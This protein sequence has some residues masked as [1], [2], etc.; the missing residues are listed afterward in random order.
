MRQNARFALQITKADAPLAHSKEIKVQAGGL[1]G[2]QQYLDH[3]N[4]ANT[5]EL[6]DDTLKFDSESSQPIKNIYQTVKV[7][8][9]RF[10][11]I[12]DFP[13]N[14]I[15]KTIKHFIIPSRKRK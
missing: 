3:K 4:A 10:G 13:Y 1:Y 7:A 9:D 14:E 15:V 12:K 5:E 11:L 8:L 6:G 2:L